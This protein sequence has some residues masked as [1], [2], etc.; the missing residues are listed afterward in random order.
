MSSPFYHAFIGTNSVRGSRGIY[1]LRI[2]PLRGT[3]EIV[4]TTQAY[5][6]GCVVLSPDAQTLYAV[7]EGMTYDGLAQG[8]LTAYRV[9]PDGTLTKINGQP[10]GG[11]RPCC[12]AV[13]AAGK[14]A[15][16]C[17]FYHGTWSAF[18]I[19]PDGGLEPP[20][21]T[22]SPPEDAAWKA[23]HCIGLM[24]GGLVGV[25]S[26]AEC[27]LVV[28]R[29]DGTRF[30]A[31][32]FPDNPFP[33]YFAAAGGNL[34]AMMQFPDDIYVLAW[35]SERPGLRLLQKIA[36]QDDARRAMPATS[37]IR[38]TPDQSLV[39]AANRPSNSISVFSRRPDGTLA[40]EDM[41]VIPGDGPRDFHISRD[42]ALAVVAMQ[43][44]DEVFVLKIDYEHK[45][46]RPLGG[47][48]KVPSPAAVAVSGRLE[49]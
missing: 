41:V 18:P 20:S 36:V 15:Y 26:L 29:P 49:L 43:H 32:P 6:S 42:G 14:T 39:L 2:D 4:S 48:V 10:T 47:P 45:T 33:R 11:Q 27:A 40:R 12:A 9:S 44:S 24:E 16:A 7:A 30:A 23:A 17:N 38:V 25:I 8:G 1:T 13:D 34:Y 21:V 19:R 28:Y 46:L 31:F 37:T 35:D 22:V 5:N 3:A